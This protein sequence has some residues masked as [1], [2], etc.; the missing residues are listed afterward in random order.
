MSP[1]H[2]E[3]PVPALTGNGLSNPDHA[4]E[5]IDQT[6]TPTRSP[7]QTKFESKTPLAASCLQERGATLPAGSR[8]TDAVAPTSEN[9]G[10]PA[11]IPDRI[12]LKHR[13]VDLAARTRQALMTF[14][15]VDS[16]LDVEGLL[17]EW[18]QLQA[19]ARCHAWLAKFAE[20]ES[21]NNEAT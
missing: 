1:P 15:L 9:H 12:F 19:L 6:S 18:R 14:E 16:D 2:N 20:Q 3:K 4:G 7:A 17:L 13:M 5:L 10:D 11:A 21:Q 8:N